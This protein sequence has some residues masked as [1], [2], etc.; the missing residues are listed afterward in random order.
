[1]MEKQLSA[2]DQAE[3][4]QAINEIVQ[5][6]IDARELSGQVT[7]LVSALS[8][9]FDMPKSAIRLAIKLMAMNDDERADLDE[10][11]RTILNIMVGD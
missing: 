3:L 8:G 2:E 7:D 10:S 9:K 5:L 11:T 6:Q 4:R 1:M